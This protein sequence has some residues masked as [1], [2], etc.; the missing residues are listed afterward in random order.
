VR[1][2]AARRTFTIEEAV[3]PVDR[4]HIAIHEILQI[5]TKGA[6]PSDT[7]AANLEAARAFFAANGE[8]EASSYYFWLGAAFAEEEAP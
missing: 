8:A 6:D 2:D 3:G 5:L 4:R 1:A 7:L